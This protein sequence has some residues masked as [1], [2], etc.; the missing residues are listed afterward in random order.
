MTDATPSFVR[1]ELASLC[2]RCRVHRLDIFGSAV[3]GRFDPARSDLDFL[4]TFRPLPPA[5]VA[6]SY[7]TLLDELARLYG[8]EIDLVTEPAL[9]N[10]HCRACVESERQNLFTQ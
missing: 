10:P 7:F 5:E 9:A 6:R 3:T 2:R 4:V 8:R 1:P